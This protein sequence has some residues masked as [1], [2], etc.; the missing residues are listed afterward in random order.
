MLQAE[1]KPAPV[2]APTVIGSRK[3]AGSDEAIVPVKDNKYDKYAP[4]ESLLQPAGAKK[5]RRAKDDSGEVKQRSSKG[6]KS[7]EDSDRVAA[8]RRGLREKE[9]GKKKKDNA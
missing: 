4:K 1:K 8:F 9:K 7:S 2:L 6:D 5:E 3:R